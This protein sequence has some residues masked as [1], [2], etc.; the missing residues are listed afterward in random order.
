MDEM[1]FQQSILDLQSNMFHFALKLTNNREEAYDLMQ[2]TSLKALD[3]QKKF[4]DNTNFKGWVLTIMRNIFI[5]NYRNIVRYQTIIDFSADLY[6]LGLPEDGGFT[7]PEKTYTYKEINKAIAQLNPDLRVAFSL[8]LAGY[9]YDEISK[10][11]KLPMGTIKS[12]IFFARQELQHT[13]KD[14]RDRT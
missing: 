8:S 7:S 13:L 11:L 5:N 9:K 10:K 14:F 3:N 6:Q 2:D 12:R 1:Q 4:V